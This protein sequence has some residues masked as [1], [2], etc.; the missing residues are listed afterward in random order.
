MRW[1]TGGGFLGIVILA[2]IVLF[3]VSRIFACVDGY[4]ACPL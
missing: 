2:I 3:I 4:G 1:D